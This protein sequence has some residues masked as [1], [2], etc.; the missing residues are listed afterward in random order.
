[1]VLYF[2]LV[3]VPVNWRVACRLVRRTPSVC[4]R[5]NQGPSK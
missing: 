3:A 1:M 2:L 4:Y 5:L